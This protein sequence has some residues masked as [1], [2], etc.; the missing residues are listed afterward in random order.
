MI[1]NDK[2]RKFIYNTFNKRCNEKLKEKVVS[3]IVKDFII[4]LGVNNIPVSR[5]KFIGRNLFECKD[6]YCYR[7]IKKN[8][9]EKRKDS[10]ELCGSKDNLTSHHIKPVKSHPYLKFNP[11]N[12]MT[13]CDSCH[14][15]LHIKN[16][17]NI[18]K[19]SE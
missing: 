7:V 6:N 17:K 1:Y 13:L 14:R 8:I 12:S 2:S 18:I 10:C 19:R 11:Q 4:E 9:K 15:I 3:R 16:S 5:M